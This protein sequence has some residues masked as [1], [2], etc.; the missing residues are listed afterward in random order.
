[1]TIEAHYKENENTWERLTITKKV[2]SLTLMGPLLA[3]SSYRHSHGMT[4]RY[5]HKA[6][7]GFSE[8]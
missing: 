7:I 1:M 8:I 2:I 4:G 5:S 3:G 6:V